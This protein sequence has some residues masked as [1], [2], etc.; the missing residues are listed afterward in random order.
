MEIVNQNQQ[1]LKM[2]VYKHYNGN[3]YLVIGL[4][5]NSETLEDLVVY[6]PLYTPEEVLSRMWVRPLEMFLS[7]TEWEGKTVKRFTYHGQR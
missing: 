7:D 6:I 2:G 5:K 4:A 3:L 1:E